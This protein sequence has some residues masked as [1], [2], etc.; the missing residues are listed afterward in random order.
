MREVYYVLSVVRPWGET[1]Q[2]ARLV[3]LPYNEAKQKQLLIMKIEEHE[4][5]LQNLVKIKNLLSSTED[6][7]GMEYDI[8]SRKKVIQQ[9]YSDYNYGNWTK[10]SIKMEFNRMALIR[11]EI[12]ESI[13]EPEYSGPVDSA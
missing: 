9:F 3:Q 2:I 8:D 4:K 10:N 7:A 11:G 1:R 13:D 12:L 5:E 6:R